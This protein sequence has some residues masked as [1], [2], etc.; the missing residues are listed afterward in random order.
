[1]FSIHRDDREVRNIVPEI[2]Y[3][4]LGFVLTPNIS[5]NDPQCRRVT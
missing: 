3:C 4:G 5:V 1:M 2:N